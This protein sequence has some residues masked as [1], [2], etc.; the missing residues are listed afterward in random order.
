MTYTAVNLPFLGAVLVV[1]VIA[2]IV[3]YR[4]RQALE[5]TERTRNTVFDVAGA[6]IVV[7]LL[8][9]IFD[10]AIIAAGIVAYDPDQISGRF[11]GL[12]PIE[13]FAYAVAA[14]VGLP[15]LWV[16]LPE[17]RAAR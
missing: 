14:G 15:A 10:N 12:A 16:L 11:V 4:R 5:S 2:F 8:T 17:R 3:E 13:D 6:L 7:V 1:A 9:A